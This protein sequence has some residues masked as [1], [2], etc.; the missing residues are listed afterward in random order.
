VGD[1]RVTAT[2]GLRADWPDGLRSGDPRCL[3]E[4]LMARYGTTIDD[5]LVLA[6][7]Y[8]GKAA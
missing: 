1:G 8:R 3:T 4:Q 7:R 2:D 6:A 5:A